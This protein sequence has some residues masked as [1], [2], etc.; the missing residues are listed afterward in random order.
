MKPLIQATATRILRSFGPLATYW[1]QVLESSPRLQDVFQEKNTSAG[2]GAYQRT[3][4]YRQLSLNSGCN[5]VS[6]PVSPLGTVITQTLHHIEGK[7][8]LAYAYFASD[9]D[10][11]WKKYNTAAPPF[12]NDLTEMGPG[13]GYW[14]RVSEDCVWSV[15]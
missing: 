9:A 4:A 3:V 6:I 15:P 1:P 7:R 11:P 12:L 10:D 13:W 5:L 8:D 2:S 14:I